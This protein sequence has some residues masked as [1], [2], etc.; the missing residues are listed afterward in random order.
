MSGHCAR[1]GWF[2]GSQGDSFPPLPITP[3]GTALRGSA[4]S[5]FFRGGILASQM[6]RTPVSRS[7]T[8]N[9]PANRP[10]TSSAP[11][12]LPEMESVPE[13]QIGTLGRVSVPVAVRVVVTL[14]V[15][16]HPRASRRPDRPARRRPGGRPGKR[17]GPWQVPG[18]PEG[19]YSGGPVRRPGVSSSGKSWCRR[20]RKRPPSRR[21]G[22]RRPGCSG[23]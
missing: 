3:A 1:D 13:R 18:A 5:D 2:H 15:G 23:G 21:R 14:A 12:K 8:S 7:C 11:P 4:T 10:C 22:S 6:S 20:G 17:K 19:W 9:T 16:Q